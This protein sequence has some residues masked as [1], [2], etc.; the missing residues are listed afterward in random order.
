MQDFFSSIVVFSL[1]P[2]K[3]TFH[4]YMHV[5]KFKK[6]IHLNN[7]NLGSVPSEFHVYNDIGIIC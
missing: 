7:L 3:Q 5:L 2:W 6:K 1:P 4:L